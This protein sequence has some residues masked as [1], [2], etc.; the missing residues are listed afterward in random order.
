MPPRKASNHWG[1]LAKP[2]I[3]LCLFPSLLQLASD[4]AQ[5]PRH[6]QTADASIAATVP[7]PDPFSP[8]QS[9]TNTR[10]PLQP[11]NDEWDVFAAVPVSE[12][13]PLEVGV[14]D[15]SPSF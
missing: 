12:M 11:A 5:S 7:L 15:M 8:L 3:L 1:D 4:R 10:D 13:V 6:A 14:H 9:V 2:T